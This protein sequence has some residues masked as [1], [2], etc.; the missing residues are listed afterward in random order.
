MRLDRKLVVNTNKYERCVNSSSFHDH[1]NAP[2][3]IQTIKFLPQ[4]LQAL[5]E[6]CPLPLM[7]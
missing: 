3:N 1:R 2:Y 7:K 4:I 5:W 6:Y